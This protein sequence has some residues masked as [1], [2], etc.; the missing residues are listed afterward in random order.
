V[1]TFTEELNKLCGF[2]YW[3]VSWWTQKR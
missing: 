3:Q 2:H 1:S